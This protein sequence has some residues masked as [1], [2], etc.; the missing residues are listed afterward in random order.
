MIIDHKDATANQTLKM[1]P[2]FKLIISTFDW[3]DSFRTL[4]PDS[5]QFSKYY[6]NQRSQGASR[7]D[8]AYHSGDVD[9]IIAE[10]IPV[11]FSYHMAHRKVIKSPNPLL[12]PIHPKGSG[13]FRIKAEVVKDEIFRMRLKDAM[14][15]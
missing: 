15:I 7:I 5:I 13:F 10:Y 9:V 2:V 8:S 12:R 14:E 4:Y 11:A 3:K 6:S 1:S